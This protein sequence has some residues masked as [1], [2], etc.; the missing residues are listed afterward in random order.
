MQTIAKKQLIQV[1]VGLTPAEEIKVRTYAQAAGLSRCR[2]I[3]KKIFSGRFPKI[4]QSPVEANA[5]LELQLM[6]IRLVSLINMY[7][8]NEL[9]FE[10]PAGLERLL[11]QQK[12]ILQI[13]LS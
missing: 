6:G 7:R 1:N 4:K 11:A 3:K 2:W 13:L 10:F 9:T 5:Y 12:K 8:A